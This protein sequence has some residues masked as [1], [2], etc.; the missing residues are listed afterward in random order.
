MIRAVL[1]DLD[2]TL[3]DSLADIADAMNRALRLHGL[4]GWRTDEYRMLVGNGA[5]VLAR[6]CVRGRQDL[7]HAVLTDYQDWYE[8]HCLDK[9]GPYPGIP[10]LVRSLAEEGILCC[11]LSNKPDA[12]TKRVVAHCLPDASFAC[13]RGQREGT[14]LKPD[15]AAALAVAD[16]IG[17]RP[18]EMLCVGDSAVDMELARAAGMPSAGACWGFRGPRELEENG[19]LFLA[20]KPSDVLGAVHALRLS[21][22]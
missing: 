7:A 16:G 6:R 1:F 21:G 14:P 12:D 22:T 8:R 11:V 13:V 9:T 15:P 10:E 17:V 4:P 20:E 2:G 19:A 5:R 3:A 18:A